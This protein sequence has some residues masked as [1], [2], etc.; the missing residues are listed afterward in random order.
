MFT[1]FRHARLEAHEAGFLVCNIPLLNS[2]KSI[3][4]KNQ[5]FQIK[6]ILFSQNAKEIKII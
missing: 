4:Q 3:H 1:V 5:M 6:M 2:Y